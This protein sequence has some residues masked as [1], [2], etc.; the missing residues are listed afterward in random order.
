V[1]AV[2]KTWVFTFYLFTLRTI[3][4]PPPFT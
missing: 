3:S 1:G 4:A 2:V